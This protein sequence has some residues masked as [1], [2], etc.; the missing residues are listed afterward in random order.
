MKIVQIIAGGY[1]HR[2]KVHAPAKLIMAGEFVCLPDD[3]ADIEKHQQEQGA[4]LF[5]PLYIPGQQ[6]QEAQQNGAHAAGEVGQPFLEGGGD[7]AAHVAGHL[8][9]GIQQPPEI[10]CGGNIQPE[11]GGELID[12]GLGGLQRS[13]GGDGENGRHAQRQQGV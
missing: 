7:A 8:A 12:A 3:E 2:P 6:K 11:A 9:H 5:L 4:E 10:L 13:Q 1:G